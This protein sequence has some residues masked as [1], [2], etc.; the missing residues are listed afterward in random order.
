MRPREMLHLIFTFLCV[1]FPLLPGCIQFVFFLVSPTH[2]CAWSNAF[3]EIFLV[4]SFVVARGRRE[5]CLKFQ[6][7]ECHGRSHIW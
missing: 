7:V 1:F 4:V 3:L 2:A 5:E 6:F